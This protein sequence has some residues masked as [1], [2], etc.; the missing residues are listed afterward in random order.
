[1][2]TGIILV[3]LIK[4]TNFKHKDTFTNIC[5]EWALCC[6]ADAI[7]YYVLFKS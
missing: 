4:G 6:I 2:I 3:L 7:W 5:V 1:M